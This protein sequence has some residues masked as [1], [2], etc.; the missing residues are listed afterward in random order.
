MISDIASTLSGVIG[1]LRTLYWKVLYFLPLPC[2]LVLSFILNIPPI[3]LSAFSVTTTEARRKNKKRYLLLTVTRKSTNKKK[4]MHK[5]TPNRFVPLSVSFY[6]QIMRKSFS[7]YCSY[8]HIIAVFYIKINLWH[9]GGYL[10]KWIN[11][12]RGFAMLKH[13]SQTVY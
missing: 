4:V 9:R 12:G 10:N 8:T 1:S 13:V 7:G 6:I 2:A 5:I 11:G 3:V